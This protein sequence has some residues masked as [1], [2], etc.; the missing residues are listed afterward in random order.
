MSISRSEAPSKVEKLE[1][2]KEKVTEIA[3]KIAKSGTKGAFNG[4]ILMFAV[5]MCAAELLGNSV[6]KQFVTVFVA[7]ILGN[8]LV[9]RQPDR[10]Q[11]NIHDKSPQ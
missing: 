1:F 10:A 3:S 9:L 7:L 2:V 5:T 6:S 11:K 4:I 8:V